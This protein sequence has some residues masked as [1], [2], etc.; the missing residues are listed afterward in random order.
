MSLPSNVQQM[1]DTM[2]LLHDLEMAFEQVG[3]GV[4]R[5]SLPIRPRLVNP[6]GGLHGGIAFT[7]ADTGMGFAVFSLIEADERASTLDMTIRYLKPAR[8]ERITAHCR[9]VR[10][11]ATIAVTQ[12]EIVNDVDEVVALAEGAFFISR[13]EG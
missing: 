13:R 9:V 5:C 3:E 7:L 12:A 10:R 1:I 4:C 6:H 2:P 8:G 11:G